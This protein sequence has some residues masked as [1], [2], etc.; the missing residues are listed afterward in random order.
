[1]KTKVLIADDHPLIAEGVQK[2]IDQSDRYEVV[3]VV[4]NGQLVLDYLENNQVDIILLDIEMPVMNGIECARKVLRD[5]PEQKIAILS[6]H[7]D[8]YTI[9]KVHESGIKG[10]MLKTIPPAELLH[11]LDTITRGGRHFDAAITEK[12]LD[13]KKGKAETRFDEQKGLISELTERELEIIKLVCQ[14]MSTKEIAEKIFVSFK[15]VDS[16]RTNIMRKLNLNNVVSL[17]RFALENDLC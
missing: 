9:K 4:E 2:T 16:H 3:Q 10:Y 14:G 5:H 6:L 13:G 11:A 8:I 7:Q 15:T 1:M 17:V 12:L